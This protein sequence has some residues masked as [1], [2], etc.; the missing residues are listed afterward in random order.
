MSV[1]AV[2]QAALVAALR[3]QRLAVT[4]VFDAPPARAARPYALVEES[5][6]GDWGTKDMAGREGRVAIALF[7]GGESPMRLRAL[8]GEAEDAILAMPRAIGEGWAVV[9]VMLLRARIAR[10]GEGRWKS[11]SEFRV[12]MLR[13]EL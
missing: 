13:S 9:S 6:L 8:A 12:R 4:A 1:Q 2:L 7:D 10:E 11:V 3:G 5:L